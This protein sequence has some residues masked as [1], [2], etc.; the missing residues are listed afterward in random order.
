MYICPYVHTREEKM[1][2]SISK[3]P[4]SLKLL[5]NITLQNALN[6]EN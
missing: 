6:E 4:P 1:I 5:D 3:I 2:I